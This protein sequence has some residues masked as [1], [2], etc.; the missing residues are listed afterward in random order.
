MKIELT[1][2]RVFFPLLL[3]IPIY[4][5]NNYENEIVRMIFCIPIIMLNVWEF[6]M[7]EVT[8]NMFSGENK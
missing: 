1:F 8:E 2:R 6:T 4:V 7:P 5:L 3:I